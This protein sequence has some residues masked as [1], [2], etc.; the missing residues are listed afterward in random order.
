MVVHPP[1]GGGVEAVV[2]VATASASTASSASIQSVIRPPHRRHAAGA[3]S[4]PGLL[5]VALDDGCAPR[6]RGVAAIDRRGS[7]VDVT[8]SRDG[9]PRGRR[10]TRAGRG[11]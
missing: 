3:G 10:P 4:P 1:V 5:G 2:L 11:G 9:P 6:R 8:S 7:A